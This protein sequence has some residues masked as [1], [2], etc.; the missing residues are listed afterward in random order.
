MMARNNTPN[1][2]IDPAEYDNILGNI[3]D[4][5]GNIDTKISF[6]LTVAC[7][8]L[9]YI[10]ENDMSLLSNNSFN[11]KWYLLAL[12]GITLVMALL[13]ISSY[14]LA[15][16]AVSNHKEP[17]YESVIF[18]GDIAKNTNFNKYNSKMSRITANELSIDKKKQIYITAQI[19]TNKVK[20]Y[21]AGLL[22]TIITVS[23]YVVFKVIVYQL[24]TL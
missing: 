13:S 16:K 10:I 12:L 5:I 23:L 24:C 22:L 17:S 1:Q 4:W 19:Y 7:V 6:L 21:N 2:N 18:A 3:K 8:F 14:I 9:G 15:L 11:S 20:R